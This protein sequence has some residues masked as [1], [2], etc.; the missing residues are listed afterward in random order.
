MAFPAQTVIRQAATLLQDRGGV[1][2]KTWEL[3]DYLNKGMEQMLGERP[4]LFSTTVSRQ[5]VAGVRQTLPA[6]ATR[7]FEV[8][9]N[10][11]GAPCRKVERSSLDF[12][13]PGW[14]Q[15]TPAGVIRNWLFD[16]RDP[17]AFEV[18]PPATTDA[19]LLLLVAQKPTP[20]TEPAGAN[21]TFA[22]VT[23]DVPISEAFSNALIDWVMYRAYLKDGQH[24]ANATRALT[25]LNA[26]RT[27][28]G[29]E[30]Q[31]TATVRPRSGKPGGEATEGQ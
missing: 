20:I 15:A 6:G 17:L 18:Y 11:N 12:V 2:F 5:L 26:Y 31:T 9:A 13:L 1:R 4:D 16:D 10:Q 24:P 7:L 29:L 8:Q 27:A 21:A 19:Q 23:G 28:L 30:V 14:R 25:H 3:V 22:D